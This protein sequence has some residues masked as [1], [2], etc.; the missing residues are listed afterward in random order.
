MSPS[1]P[2]TQES[3]ATQGFPQFHRRTAPVPHPLILGLV[4]RPGK[5]ESKEIVSLLR[6]SP[7]SCYLFPK[8]KPSDCHGWGI[9]LSQGFHGWARLL[10]G[11]WRTQDTKSHKDGCL[12]GVRSCV[13][14]TYRM[15]CWGSPTSHL[16]AMRF[17]F[18][19]VT[20]HWNVTFNSPPLLDQ[21]QVCQKLRMGANGSWW[22]GCHGPMGRPAHF[23][24]TLY[25]SILHLRAG[26]T[27]LSL[28]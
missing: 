10:Q 23:L 28:V 14:E 11:S 27:I 9:V 15:P 4:L 18:Q 1:L 3:P 21:A 6:V 12:P 8:T 7:G 2:G 17:H 26:A 24:S 16:V 20:E 19:Q 22:P 25:Q 13:L 5:P